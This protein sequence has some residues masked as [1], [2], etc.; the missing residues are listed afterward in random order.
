MKVVIWSSLLMRRFHRNKLLTVASFSSVDATQLDLS[1][2]CQ[3]WQIVG[4]QVMNAKRRFGTA[5]LCLAQSALLIFGNASCAFAAS[6][7]GNLMMQTPQ[8]DEVPIRPA[9]LAVSPTYGEEP[10]S[11]AGDLLQSAMEKYSSGDVTGAEKLFKRVLIVDKNNADAY[12]N[13]GVLYE[14]KGDLQLALENYTRAQSLNPSDPEL[15]DTVASLK[16]KVAQERTAKISEAKRAEQADQAA[17]RRED[18]REMVA[19][20]SADYK[21]GNFSE[22]VR[23]LE[24][25]AADAPSDPDV[26]YALGQAYKA[27]GDTNKARTAFGRAM[28]IDPSSQLYRDALGDLNAIASAPQSPVTPMTPSSPMDSQNDDSPAG[29]ITPFSGGGDSFA[30]NGGRGIGRFF[31]GGVTAS[32][33]RGGSGSRLKRAV[34]GGAMGAAAGA[35]FAASTRGGMKRGAIQGAILGG[36]LGYFSGR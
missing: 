20:A 15:R 36:M 11:P 17:K 24:R 22:A 14:G 7:L 30:S 23:K 5:T 6:N 12:F 8:L 25:V 32:Y 13:L 18:L 29:Q 1:N 9:P 28:S 16:T 34:A 26:Q 10:K 33:G 4:V 3:F 31:D 27:K 21:S 19:S 2:A 35:L